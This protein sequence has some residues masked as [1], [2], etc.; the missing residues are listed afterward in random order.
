MNMRSNLQTSALVA[1]LMLIGPAAASAQQPVPIYGVTAQMA[2]EGTVEKTY[3]GLNAV[4]VEA[5]HGLGYVFHL[6]ER[7]VVH[8]GKTAGDDVLRGLDEGSRVVVHSTVEGERRTADAIDRVGVDGLKTVEGVITHVDRHAKTMSIQL[9]DGSRQTFRLTERAAADVGKDLDRAAA[10][11]ATVVVYIN[12]EA[13]RPI[14]HVFT[15]IL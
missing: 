7:T 6:T 15:R 14:A 11:T 8:G 5:R 1:G 12:D 13:G 10:G 4:L 2:L 3:E 9:A